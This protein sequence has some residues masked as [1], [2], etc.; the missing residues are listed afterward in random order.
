MEK[1]FGQCDAFSFADFD[2]CPRAGALVWSNQPQPN[3]A[4][5]GAQIQVLAL[6]DSGG[7]HIE[8]TKA[9]MPW[10]GKCGEENGFEVEIIFTTRPPSRKLFWPNTGW[11]CNWILFRTAGHPRQNRRFRS[12]SNKERAAGWASITP[13]FWASLTGSL[14]GR[15]FTNSWAASS[16]RITFQISAPERFM[17]RTARI[18]A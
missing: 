3:V 4:P 1:N 11:C 7:H 5:V 2:H 15:G 12:I 6:A 14:C 10:L 9:A 17:W 18:R 16:S 8:F 13:R